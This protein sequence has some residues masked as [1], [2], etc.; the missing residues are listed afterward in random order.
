MV[1]STFPTTPLFFLILFVY[2]RFGAVK[3]DTSYRVVGISQEIGKVSRV[4]NEPIDFNKFPIGSLVEIYPN[5]SCLTAALYLMKYLCENLVFF[6]G[7]NTSPIFRGGRRKGDGNLDASQRV[8][9]EYHCTTSNQ[10]RVVICVVSIYLWHYTL[11]FMFGTAARA[12][13]DA[14]DIRGVYMTFCSGFARH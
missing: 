7:T 8:V 14:W 12:C 4:N 5:H 9:I 13:G 3:G 6:N 10:P 1:L 11:V 2:G